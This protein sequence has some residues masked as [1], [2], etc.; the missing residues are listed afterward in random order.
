M[1]RAIIDAATEGADDA[2]ICFIPHKPK[3]DGQQLIFNLT[4]S[5]LCV[6]EGCGRVGHRLSLLKEH[7][8]NPVHLM[9]ARLAVAN[10]NAVTQ[11]TTT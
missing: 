7:P 3:L 1:S 11:A 9:T 4:V 10:Q 5:L 6:R 8:S 2:G